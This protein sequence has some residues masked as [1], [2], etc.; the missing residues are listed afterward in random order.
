MLKY[1]HIAW[2]FD[3]TLYDSYPFVIKCY[4]RTLKDYGVTADPD[5]VSALIHKTLRHAHD[6]YAP[7]CG[8]PL[9]ELR[10]RYKGY[11]YAN[12]GPSAEVLPVPGIPELLRDIVAAGGKN[13]IC[14]NRSTVE[15]RAYLERDGLAQYFDLYAGG[16]MGLKLKPTGEMYRYLQETS[17][18]RP[19][20]MLMVGDRPLDYLE[21]HA[22]GSPGCFFEPEGL[23]EFPDDAE[24]CCHTVEDLRNFLF[25]NA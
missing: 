17:G 3:G 2:D 12:E 22:A 4:L 16:E 11:E 6:R 8:V 15:C 24:F 10:T 5:E 9:A 19:E 25:G 1:P 14:S 18:A 23:A 13:H 20:Q 7:E 21:A